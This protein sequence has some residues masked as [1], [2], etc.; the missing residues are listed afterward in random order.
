MLDP[1]DRQRFFRGLRNGL[2][3]SVALWAVILLCTACA[4]QC[5]GTS[6]VYTRRG[7]GTI[8]QVSVSGWATAAHVSTEGWRTYPD[9]DLATD[10]DVSVT[11]LYR[12]WGAGSPR[13]GP[14][15][16]GGAIMA[17]NQVIG[18]ITR[19]GGPFFSGELLMPLPTEP[20]AVS[21]AG[22]PG[23]A[24]VEGTAVVYTQRF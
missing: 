20:T 23:G 17:D 5:A 2:G 6:I 14:G 4:V 22:F 10:G 7:Q 18:I 11:S 24:C 1:C 15:A 9:R 8:S 21:F 3:I 19:A 16:N 12:F 13:I